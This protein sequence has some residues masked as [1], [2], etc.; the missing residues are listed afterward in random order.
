LPESEFI[1]PATI[2]TRVDLP[3]PFSPANPR[4]SPLSILKDTLFNALVAINVLLISF[5]S[6]IDLSSI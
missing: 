1:I 2:D 4:I 3:D 6:R 5:N